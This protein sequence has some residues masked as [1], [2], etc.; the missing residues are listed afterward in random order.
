M[1]TLKWEI[2]KARSKSCYKQINKFTDIE[3]T[4]TQKEGRTITDIEFTFLKKIPF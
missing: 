4:Y 1:N 2:L 3:V